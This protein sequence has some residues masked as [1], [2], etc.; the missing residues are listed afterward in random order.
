VAE[1][2]SQEWLDALSA[3]KV[4]G[5][6]GEAGGEAGGESPGDPV[7]PG[8]LVQHVVSNAPDGTVPYW[9]RVDRGRVVEASLGQAEKADLTLSV[10]YDDAVRI[11]RGELELSAAYMQG[12]LKAEGDMTKLFALLRSTHLAWR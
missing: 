6:G 9:T 1:V 5:D 7:A 10:A 8:F 3:G 4:D 12:R 2:L 11:D